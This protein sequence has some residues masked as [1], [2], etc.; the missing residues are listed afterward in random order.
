MWIT[1]TFE[2]VDPDGKMECPWGM[3][4]DL[5]RKVCRMG[6]LERFNIKGEEVSG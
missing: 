2:V 4:V 5:I 6:R 1:I 3:K